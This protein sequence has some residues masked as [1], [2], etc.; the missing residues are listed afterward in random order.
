VS[1]E[2][3]SANLYTTLSA[4]AGLLALIGDGASPNIPR[5]SPLYR[6]QSGT[7][8]Y[9]VFQQL[10]DESFNIL[11]NS[12]GGGKRKVRIQISA[13]SPTHKEAFDVAEQVRLAMR[14]ATLYKSS[15]ISSQDFFEPETKL[16]SVIADYS[17]MTS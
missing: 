15:Y 12:G 10:F 5:L 16:Y 17:V 7:D 4:H 6:G 8:P 11:N 13:F 3:L 1:I 14:D 9:V 2:T